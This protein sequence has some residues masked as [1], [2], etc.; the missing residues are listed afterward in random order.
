MGRSRREE[1]CCW[2][3]V[4]HESCRCSTLALMVWFPCGWLQNMFYHLSSFNGVRTLRYVEEVTYMEVRAA[5]MCKAER[6]WAVDEWGGW[7][8]A[9]GRRVAAGHALGMR[10]AGAAHLH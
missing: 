5:A 8:G 7:V 9:G 2:P 1:S 3:C 4:R 6:Q 10:A